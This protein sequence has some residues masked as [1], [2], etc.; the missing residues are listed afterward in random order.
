MAGMKVKQTEYLNTKGILAMADHYHRL[1]N[2]PSMISQMIEIERKWKNEIEALY[3]DYK[4]SQTYIDFTDGSDEDDEWEGST[5]D[6]VCSNCSGE[7]IHR[8]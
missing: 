7:G 6:N 1:K 2:N 3:K 8:M 5:D 4:Q